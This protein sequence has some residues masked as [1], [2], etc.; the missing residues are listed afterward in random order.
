MKSQA[1]KRIVDILKHL[2]HH[3]RRLQ[4]H[5][6][7]GPPLKLPPKV[8]KFTR[9]PM[10]LVVGVRKSQA[11]FCFLGQHEQ[12]RQVCTGSGHRTFAPAPAASGLWSFGL[13][14]VHLVSFPVFCICLR[15]FLFSPVGF[16]GNQS[17]LEILFYFF[18]GS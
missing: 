15:I 5:D 12:V 18:Q 13:P 14:W 3:L 6:M 9:S 7:P 2:S 10:G 8:G 16:N 11:E 4:M 1:G 17:L